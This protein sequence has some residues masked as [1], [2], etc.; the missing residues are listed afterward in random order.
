MEYQRKKL[1]QIFKKISIE[2]NG[3]GLYDITNQIRDF[4]QETSVTNAI[5]NLFILHTSCSLIIQENASLEVKEDLLTFFDELA[6]MDKNLY[7]HKIEGKDDMPAHIKSTLTNVNLTLNI[8]NK[9]I[10]L[11]IWQGIFLFE[12]RLTSQKRKLS[13]HLIGD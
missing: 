5:L 8:Q 10:V 11:G 1:V 3:Q 13:L 4:V 2:T 9:E 7:S 12:H 6:P